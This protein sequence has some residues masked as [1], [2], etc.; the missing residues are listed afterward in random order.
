MYQ[1][2]VT[3]LGGTSDNV[4]KDICSVSVEASWQKKLEKYH[5]PKVKK[6]TS[7]WTVAVASSWKTKEQIL[8]QQFWKG[9]D[10]F[11]FKFRKKPMKNWDKITVKYKQ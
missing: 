7:K 6:R 3:K 10:G 4:E 1:W 5:T 11:V 8:L 2:R 9:N